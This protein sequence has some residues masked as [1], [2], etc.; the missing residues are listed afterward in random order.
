MRSYPALL[1]GRLGVNKE[2]QN[3]GIGKEVMEFIKA[4]FIDENNKTGCRFIVVDSYNETKPL[5]YY[6]K[7]GFNF[8]FNDEIQERKY[9]G[10]NKERDLV[11]RLMYFD[12]ILLRNQS[13]PFSPV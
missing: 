7:N 8:L 4:W 11:T 9:T 13:P 12:L 10:L 1:I 3:K 5:N 2:Y 6:N